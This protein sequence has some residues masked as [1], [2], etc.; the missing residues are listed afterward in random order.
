L[1]RGWRTFSEA[2]DERNRDQHSK[3]GKRY[4]YAARPLSYNLR[5]DITEWIKGVPP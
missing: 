4:R 5:A 2:R 3:L 1:K